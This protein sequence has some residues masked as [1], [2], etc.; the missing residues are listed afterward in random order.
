MKSNNP[1]AICA[2]I[3]EIAAFLRIPIR[4][5]TTPH[6]VAF[7]FADPVPGFREMWEVP[8]PETDPEAFLPVWQVAKA[9]AHAKLPARTPRRVRKAKAKLMALL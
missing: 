9:A 5:R 3:E 8:H 7:Y 4:R 1:I 2:A 6:T